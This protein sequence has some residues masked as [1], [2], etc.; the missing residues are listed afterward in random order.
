MDARSSVA[1]AVH[2]R[3]VLRR[4]A[5]E[6]IRVGMLGTCPTSRPW[7]LTAALLTA[8][9]AA[10]C[11]HATGPGTP[12]GPPS[13]DVTVAPSQGDVPFGYV[14][15]IQ[16]AG[17]SLKSAVS[18]RVG[19][20]QV[21]IPISGP[22]TYTRS[23][24]LRAPTTDTLRFRIESVNGRQ[25][26]ATAFVS[27]TNTPP[28]ITARSVSRDSVALGDSA[29]VRFVFSDTR[30]GFTSQIRFGNASASR[31]ARTSIDTV[32]LWAR[33][34]AAGTQYAIATVIDPCGAFALDSV[35][36]RSFIDP[37][38]PTITAADMREWIARLSDD[39][40]RGRASPG[41]EIETAALAIA[42]RFE[43]LG[44]SSAFGGSFIQ[45][46][47]CCESGTGETAPNVGGMLEG[48]DPLLKTEFVVIVA[49]FDA[50]GAEGP[51]SR[52]VAMGADA[53]CNG[54]NDNAS[55]TA[56]V[57]ELAQAFAW[58]PMRPLRSVL[59]LAVSG[60]EEGLWG[61]EHF[62]ANPPIPL[63]N[64][65]AA[66]NVDMIGRNARDSVFVEGL[67]RSTLGDRAIAIAL[68]HPEQGLWLKSM[69]LFA[70]SD[71]WP[72]YQAGIPAISFYNGW[73]AEYHRPTDT[74][75]LIDADLAARTVRIVFYTAL[76]VLNA[77][78]RP[79]WH[80]GAQVPP[81]RP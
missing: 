53:I 31:L 19:G 65:V 59:F 49:H 20:R 52:C 38:A 17:D 14:A 6:A 27:G 4:D 18:L 13:I 10:A 76:D 75:D 26:S 79:Q 64:V 50:V 36:V 42:A 34:A 7:R 51:S 41:A 69:G 72:F 63:A 2:P 74:V 43:E 28:S 23:D 54:A 58:A 3:G 48:A 71:H 46:F 61:S 29:L 67:D 21:F 73:N 39:S 66:L 15:T 68:A 62:T 16:V 30:S 32:G 80:A 45:H 8:L 55:G 57:L 11:E 40:L 5:G 22:G 35:P 24:T 1:E 25:D 37:G 47:S 81:A 60:E 9:L 44:L 78:A 56:A 12:G 77:P 33:P 70:N